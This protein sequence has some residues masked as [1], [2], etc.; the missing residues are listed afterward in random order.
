MIVILLVFAILL[1]YRK[2]HANN[3]D[4]C[5]QYGMD[6]IDRAKKTPKTAVMFDIDGTLI[7]GP[8]PIQPM[9]ELCNYAKSQG[10]TVVIIT[11]RPNYETIETF[12]RNQLAKHGVH[13][14]ILKLCPAVQ[15]KTLK[16]RMDLDIIL[17]IGDNWTD[18]DGLNS[19]YFIKLK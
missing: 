17:S 15:K 19:G 1:L 8:V 3:Y 16:E 13:Y 4:T 18:V 7:N 9:I 12:T 5:K 10:I 11:A 14:D 6:V 2:Y